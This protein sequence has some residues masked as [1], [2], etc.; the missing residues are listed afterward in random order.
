M[1]Q[2]ADDEPESPAWQHGGIKV[3]VGLLD[4]GGSAAESAAEY[5]SFTYE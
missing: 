5:D 2:M 3:V 4:A 1:R